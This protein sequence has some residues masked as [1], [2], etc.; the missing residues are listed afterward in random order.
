MT[1]AGATVSF[2]GPN[3]WL[4]RCISRPRAVACRLSVLS[5]LIRD[6]VSWPQGLSAK[7]RPHPFHCAGFPWASPRRAQC[8]GGLQRAVD[9]VEHVVELAA[10]RR[11]GD[12][13]RNRDQG[14]EQCVFDGI[15]ARVLNREIPEQFERGH[16]VIAPFG[17]ACGSSV[18]AGGGC[19]D[20]RPLPDERHGRPKSDSN[21]ETQL[22]R[23]LDPVQRPPAGAGAVHSGT[24]GST[25]RRRWLSGTSTNSASGWAPALAA[26]SRRAY[27]A[28]SGGAVSPWSRTLSRIVQ[29]ATIRKALEDWPAAVKR[30]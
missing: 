13:D 1:S 16:R 4:A 5:F 30:S 17:D 28:A 6:P 23:R 25:C 11:D 15:G 7:D 18:S 21:H 2:T 29:V 10:Q 19:D 20:A 14:D 26:R 12:D 8:S 27:Q 3:D 22:C 24:G 9:T